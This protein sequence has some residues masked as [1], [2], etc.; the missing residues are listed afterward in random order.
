MKMMATITIIMMMA[1]KCK[2]FICCDGFFLSFSFSFLV[3]ELYNRS[4]PCQHAMKKNEDSDFGALIFCCYGQSMGA[5]MKWSV[6]FGE[7]VEASNNVRLKSKG[8][9]EIDTKCGF[10]I[11]MLVI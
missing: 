8:G 3:S 11:F 9:F 7:P 2:I 4:M 10:V 6:Q 5:W 1:G